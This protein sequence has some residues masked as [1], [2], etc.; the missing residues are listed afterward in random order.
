MNDLRSTLFKK[1]RL[2]DKKMREE[3]ARFFFF[4]FSV[5][6]FNHNVVNCLM[7]FSFFKIQN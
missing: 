4:F 3:A 1:T 6:H 7:Y 2:V 5:K